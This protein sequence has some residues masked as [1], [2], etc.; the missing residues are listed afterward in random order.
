MTTKKHVVRTRIG[1]ELKVEVGNSG[2]KAG[3]VPDKPV[4]NG[5]AKG[6]RRSRLEDEG[7]L[8][9]GGGS[10]LGRIT[11]MPLPMLGGQIRR[12]STVPAAVGCEEGEEQLR[13]K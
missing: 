5:A 7:Q 10:D 13:E 3:V 6:R 1:S 9:D 11:S 2:G 4:S 8:R 12:S